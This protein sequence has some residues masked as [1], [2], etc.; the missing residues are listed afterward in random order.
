MLV[1]QINNATQLGIRVAFGFLDDDSSEQDPEVLA[2]IMNSGGRYFTIQNYNASKAFINGIIVNGLT[3]NDN[4]QG[5]TTTL[6]AGLDASHFISGSETQ[7]MTYSARAKEQLTFTVDSINAGTLSVQIVSGGKT[8]AKGESDYYSTPFSV[9]APSTNK[10]DVKVTA[11]DADKNSIFVVGVTSNLPPQNCTVGVGPAVKPNDLPKKVG[12]PV[13]VV[14]GLLGCGGCAYLIFKYCYKPHHGMQSSTIGNP[15]PAYPGGPKSVPTTVQEVPAASPSSVPWFKFPPHPPAK[16]LP[17]KQSKPGDHEEL[18]SNGDDHHARTKDDD[19]RDMK[20]DSGSEVSADERDPSQ[21]DSHHHMHHIRMRTY[22]NNHHHHLPPE[23]PCYNSK[24]PI[25]NHV[26]EDP[27]YPCTCVDPKCKLNSRRHKCKDENVLHTCAGPENDPRCP[28]NDPRYA[29]MKKEE[30]DGL[31]R[32]Y[33]AQ[34]MAKNAVK[35]SAMSALQTV[36]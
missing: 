6:L 19:H 2:A 31:V 22:G 15:P 23:H 14:V 11:D 10:I 8:L 7:T 35:I 29:K 5:D 9:V 25:A 12:I 20:E 30:R 17:P 21:P 32:K 13:G 16:H 24:C 26:C 28:L 18:K 34:D 1:D 3:K 4:P 36:M 27:R 33:V